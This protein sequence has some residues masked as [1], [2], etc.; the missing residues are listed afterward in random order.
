MEYFEGLD[1]V[2]VMDESDLDTI[3][4]P[5]LAVLAG[6]KGIKFQESPKYPL[7]PLKTTITDRKSIVFDQS[8]IKVDHLKINPQHTLK[9]GSSSSRL[10][11]SGGSPIKTSVR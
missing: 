6:G 11:T 2:T 5:V 9:Q 8:P 1:F 7:K 3:E 4:S 10:V